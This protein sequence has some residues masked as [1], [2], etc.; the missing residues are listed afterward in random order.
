[1]ALTSTRLAAKFRWQS[2]LRCCHP[3]WP[4]RCL[5]NQVHAWL[6]VCV[7]V[8]GVWWWWV[9]GCGVGCTGQPRLGATCHV[10]CTT[11]AV[12]VAFGYHYLLWLLLLLWCGACCS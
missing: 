6:R 9:V 8:C 3:R 5:A 1:M 2:H 11:V 12:A 10:P 7:S 4:A